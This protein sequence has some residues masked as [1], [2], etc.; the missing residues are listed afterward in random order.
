M[1]LSVA[2]T[3][4]GWPPRAP[5]EPNSRSA[6]WLSFVTRPSLSVTTTGS[7]KE[8]IAAS[9]ICCAT[10]SLPRSDR[11]GAVHVASGDATRGR[12]QETH[13]P[14]DRI[15]QHDGKTKAGSYQRSSQQDR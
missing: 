8:S 10:P 2:T 15:R 14:D 9:V 6:A 7:Y 12:R 3:E 1:R 11:R 13:G 5:S 4:I